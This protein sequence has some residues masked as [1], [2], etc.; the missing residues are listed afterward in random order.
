MSIHTTHVCQA[1]QEPTP[2][3]DLQ[4]VKAVLMCSTCRLGTAEDAALLAQTADEIQTERLARITRDYLDAVARA[5]I[6]PD[7]DWQEDGRRSADM[8]GRALLASMSVLATAALAVTLAWVG[9]WI[10]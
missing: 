4:P 2:L 7:D 5:D 10:A 3:A 9:G 1:C 6:E 8:L